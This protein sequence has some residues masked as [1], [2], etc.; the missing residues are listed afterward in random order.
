VLAG[1]PVKKLEGF[2]GARFY[3]LHALT[4]DNQRI[5]IRGEDA[6]VLNG[7]ICTVFVSF[8]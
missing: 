7:V 3:R 1:T 4:D 5:R 6:R 8:K 2:L